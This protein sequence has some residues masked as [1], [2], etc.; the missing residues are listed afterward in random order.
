MFYRPC[1][2]IIYNKR[3]GKNRPFATKSVVNMFGAGASS[4]RF[5]C[6]SDFAY[7]VFPSRLSVGSSPCLRPNRVI[8]ITDLPHRPSCSRA[9][10]AECSK[11]NSPVLV[12]S[13]LQHALQ[14][15]AHL[16]ERRSLRRV[17]CPAS[18]DEAPKQNKTTI[19]NMHVIFVAKDLLGLVTMMAVVQTLIK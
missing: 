9:K 14:Q 11:S 17:F 7:L 4:T 6:H 2:S 13:V 10:K 8:A 18:L 15:V 5:A 12:D 19:N 1:K 3:Y 16:G